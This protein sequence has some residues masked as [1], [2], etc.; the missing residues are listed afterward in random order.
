MSAELASYALLFSRIVTGFVFGLSGIGKLRDMRAFEQALESFRVLPAGLARVSAYLFVIGELTVVALMLL[1]GRFLLPGFGLGVLLL[2]IFS[3]ALLSVLV[4]RLDTPC[5]CFGPS[6]KPVSYF[7][8]LR[9]A[10]L[11]GC[12]L[13]GWISLPGGQTSLGVAEIALLGLMA[14]TIST[15]WIHIGELAESFRTL[16]T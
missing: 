1:G 2:L 8:L 6:D 11:I 16:K 13:L 14:V 10:G 9:N 3:I 5:N 7:D 15:L 12:A 4:R